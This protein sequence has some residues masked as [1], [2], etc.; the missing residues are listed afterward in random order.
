MGRRGMV[1]KYLHPLSSVR[2]VFTMNY[3]KIKKIKKEEGAKE[4]RMLT[5]VWIEVNVKFHFC[6]GMNILKT[7]IYLTK[8]YNGLLNHLMIII[9]FNVY[10]INV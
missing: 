9:F 1:L 4:L 10:L 8:R 3:L 7:S 6:F 2:I 5:S